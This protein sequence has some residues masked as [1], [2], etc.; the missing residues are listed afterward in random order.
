MGANQIATRE[1][2]H[3]GHRDRECLGQRSAIGERLPEPRPHRSERLPHP[4]L[5]PLVAGELGHRLLGVAPADARAHG[6]AAIEG[7]DHVANDGTDQLGLGEQP[8][9]TMV[10]TT[11][12]LSSGSFEQSLENPLA[13]LHAPHLRRLEAVAARDLRELRVEILLCC[14]LVIE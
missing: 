11:V 4:R 7:V 1:P 8:T 13:R 12:R 5:A 3:G 10:I 14:R 6:N 9:R 2:I